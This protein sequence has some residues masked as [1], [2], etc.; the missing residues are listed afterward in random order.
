MVTNVS[1]K[2]FDEFVEFTN[3][4]DPNGPPVLFYF[5]SKLPDGVTSWC[6]DCVVAEP[7]VRACLN[8][9]KKDLI[10]VHVDCG[11]RDFYRD[12][13]CVFRTDGRSKIRRIPTLLRWKGPRLEEAECIDR[14]KLA[15]LF[16]S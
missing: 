4:I 2:G 13:Q 15:K 11:P 12:P 7:V 9:V 16:E 6:P 3:R 5:D 10:F 8:D 1:I 14:D